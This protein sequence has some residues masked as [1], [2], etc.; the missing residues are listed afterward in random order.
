MAENEPSGKLST[1]LTEMPSGYSA[2]LSA[3]FVMVHTGT[4]GCGDAMT[5]SVH[6]DLVVVNPST[7]TSV[8]V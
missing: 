4:V 6:P 3:V 1:H 5:M 7:G 2:W 8:T